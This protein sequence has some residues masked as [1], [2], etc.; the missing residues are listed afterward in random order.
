MSDRPREDHGKAE[1]T[2]DDVRDSGDNDAIGISPGI[3]SSARCGVRRLGRVGAQ[4][5]GQRLIV[6]PKPLYRVRQASSRRRR[7]ADIAI[8]RPQLAA[9]GIQ[10]VG[11]ERRVIRVLY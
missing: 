7:E 6:R 1:D 10:K 8:C 5:V 4:K 9:L 3:R 11:R 2:Q